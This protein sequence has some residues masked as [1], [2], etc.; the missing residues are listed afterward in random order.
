MVVFLTTNFKLGHSTKQLASDLSAYSDD[1]NNIVEA[2][3]SLQANPTYTSIMTWECYSFAELMPMS[4]LL[5]SVP[6]NEKTV[7]QVAV[8]QWC[9]PIATMIMF[10]MCASPVSQNM[11]C[12]WSLVMQKILSQ[13]PRCHWQTRSSHVDCRQSFLSSEYRVGPAQRA[14]LCYISRDFAPVEIMYDFSRR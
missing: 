5:F 1:N 12:H 9:H 8:F 3:L 2:L 6:C 11:T 13:F 4:K 10:S 14:T 7:N